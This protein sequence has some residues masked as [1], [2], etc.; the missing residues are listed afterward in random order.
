[1]STERAG[2]GPDRNK[3]IDLHDYYA[4]RFVLKKEKKANFEFICPAHLENTIDIYSS[5][6]LEPTVER[7]NYSR[8]CDPYEQGPYDEDRGYYIT[9]W[10]KR[11]EVPPDPHIDWTQSTCRVF[12]RTEEVVRVGFE[13][14]PGN[15]NYGAIV[16]TVRFK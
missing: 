11:S 6:T 1:M 14:I 10:H 9:G 15:H 16:C 13:D 2:Y 12:A 7:G 3:S 5:E 8:S 4:C